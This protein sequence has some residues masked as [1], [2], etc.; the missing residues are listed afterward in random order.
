MVKCLGHWLEDKPAGLAESD[1]GLSKG[2]NLQI[3][4]PYGIMRAQ[5]DLLTPE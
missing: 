1:R 2:I 5:I 4:L 3:N